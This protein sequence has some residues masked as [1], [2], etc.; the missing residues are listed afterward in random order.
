MEEISWNLTYKTRFSKCKL[1]NCIFICTIETYSIEIRFSVENWHYKTLTSVAYRLGLKVS[2][3]RCFINFPLF[4]MVRSCIFF[5]LLL[6]IS[7]LADPKVVSL[8]QTNSHGSLTFT[9][10]VRILPFWNCSV[11]FI[12]EWRTNL[13]SIRWWQPAVEKY[14]AYNGKYD[15]PV[16]LH[17]ILMKKL[18]P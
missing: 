9:V 14:P 15:Y 11:T 18:E 5:L 12:L 8:S 17:I 13:S 3:N 2:K 1:S 4:A 7:V 6:I 10:E 16:I